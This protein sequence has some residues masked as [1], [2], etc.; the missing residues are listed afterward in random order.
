M[1]RDDRLVEL[2]RE[3]HTA[4]KL[5]RQLKRVS[6]SRHERDAASR[7]VRALRIDLEFHFEEEEVMLLPVLWRCGR[8]DLAERLCSEHVELRALLCEAIDGRA[9]ELLGKRLE[10]YVRFEEREMFPGLEA[11]WTD[12]EVVREGAPGFGA[13]APVWMHGRAAMHSANLGGN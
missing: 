1:K 3:H 9:L 4:L 12:K 11:C 7:M 2:S 5:A 6:S 10:A 8:S 13:D